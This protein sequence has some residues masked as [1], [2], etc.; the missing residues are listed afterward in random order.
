MRWAALVDSGETIL[1]NLHF[2][3]LLSFGAEAG[4]AAITAAATD[5]VIGC[6]GC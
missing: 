3:R 4:A 5:G 2:Q 6:T 1:Q